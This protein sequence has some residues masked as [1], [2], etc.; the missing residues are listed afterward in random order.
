LSGAQLYVLHTLS[1][2]ERLSV[3]ELADRVRTHQS[4]VSVVVRKLVDR[5]LVRRR[6]SETDARR[7]ELALTATGRQLLRCA[8][9]AAQERLV[10]GI[11]R[12]QASTRKQLAASLSQLVGAMALGHEP[13]PMLFDD[14]E[15][16]LIARSGRAAATAGSNGRAVRHAIAKRGRSSTRA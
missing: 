4:T 10:A 3:N 13:A 2:A 7:V 8:P 12:L 6:E 9:G 1:M 15:D 11:E 16:R 14:A 5:G